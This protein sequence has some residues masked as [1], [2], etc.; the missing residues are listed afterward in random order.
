M[1]YNLKNELDAKNARARLE[2]LEKRGSVIELT[3][4]KPRRTISQNSYLHLILSYFAVQTGNTLEWVKQQYYKKYCNPDIFVCEKEDMLMGRRIKYI[5]S[6]SELSTDERSLSISRFRNWSASE[7]GIYL[8]EATNEAEML[9]L[10]VEVDR[11][12]TYI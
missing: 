4:K 5:R 3:E 6:S 9:A 8:P 11:Y 12:K 1:I 10:Q 2:L 7:A